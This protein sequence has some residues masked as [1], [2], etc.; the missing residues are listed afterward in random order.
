MQADNG[1]QT[2]WRIIVNDAKNNVVVLH[3]TATS[4]SAI[5]P[6]ENE[7][8]FVLYFTPEGDAITRI[9]ETVDSKV[10]TDFFARLNLASK[11]NPP[12]KL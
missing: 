7:Y 2:K 1:A 6:Y 10:T 5:G 9:E 4:E 11:A 12:A 3:I 8:I